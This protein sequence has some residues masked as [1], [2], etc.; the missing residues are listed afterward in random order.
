MKGQIK[1]RILFACGIRAALTKYDGLR[2]SEFLL[3]HAVLCNG[4][5]CLKPYCD[6]VLY[7]PS[8]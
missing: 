4:Y 3:K 2:K 5:L 8:V 6:S 7:L 1:A